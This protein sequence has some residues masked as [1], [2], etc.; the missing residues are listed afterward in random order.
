MPDPT[1]FT[2]PYDNR[3]LFSDHYIETRL[4]EQKAFR[5][6]HEA[7]D[8]ALDD[9]TRLYASVE[10]K[11]ETWNEGETEDE[12]VRPVLE[13]ILGW[14]RSVQKRVVRQGREGRPD[15]ALFT[16][17]ETAGATAALAGEPSTGEPSTGVGLLL[18]T[19]GAR[20]VRE[21]TVVTARAH[22]SRRDGEGKSVDM[23]V[24]DGENGRGVARSPTTR[25][26]RHCHAA[27][28][29]KQ[30]TD[31]RTSTDPQGQKHPQRVPSGASAR[32]DAAGVGLFRS[33]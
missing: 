27:N 24:G 28:R 26:E 22:E 33:S 25:T 12:F 16:S 4:P 9:L 31:R 3:E 8:A 5:E 2:T 14:E 18:G 11:T 21:R 19:G 15:Y 7:A 17:A 30:A 29:Q 13:E 32:H 23:T 20:R 6:L 10:S 1:I